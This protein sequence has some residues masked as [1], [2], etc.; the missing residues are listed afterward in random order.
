MDLAMP[1]VNGVEATRQ[2]KV[3]WP[4]LAVIITT[5]HEDDAYR[6]IALAAGADV[7][8]LKKTLGVDLRPTLAEVAARRQAQPS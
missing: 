5:V 7:V 3:R 2:F 1:R 6:R 4:D 8:L